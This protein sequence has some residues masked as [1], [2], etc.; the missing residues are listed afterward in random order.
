MLNPILKIQKIELN[1]GEVVPHLLSLNV[2]I[3]IHE[4]LQLFTISAITIILL[5]ELDHQLPE[6][7][8]RLDIKKN[9]LRLVNDFVYLVYC[10]E[11]ISKGNGSVMFQS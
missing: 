7:I 9:L 6:M 4:L 5:Q 10:R 1:D 11:N 3:H 2:C 8:I